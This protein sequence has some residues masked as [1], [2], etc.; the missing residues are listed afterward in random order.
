MEKQ[1]VLTP[2]MPSPPGGYSG[3]A[4]DCAAFDRLLAEALDRAH[5]PPAGLRHLD[6]CPQCA[7]LLADFE[8]MAGKVRLLSQAD[9]VEVPDQWAQIRAVLLREG[10]IHANGF[11]CAQAPP[12]KKAPRLVQRK[13]R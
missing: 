11:S 4:M 8:A 9:V 2:P 3:G 5:L 12:G 1:T 10:I 6:E 13:K 7:G